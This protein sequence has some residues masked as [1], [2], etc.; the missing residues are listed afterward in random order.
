MRNLTKWQWHRVL[1]ALWCV[2]LVG[3]AALAAGADDVQKCIQIAEKYI[4]SLQ[5]GVADVLVEDYSP[6][7][8]MNPSRE[9]LY[10]KATFR[11]GYAFDAKTGAVRMDSEG[12]AN[13]FVK[14]TLLEPTDELTGEHPD[15]FLGFRH[16]QFY[17]GGCLASLL[18]QD[19]RTISVDQ[20]YHAPLHEEPLADPVWL[21]R[22]FLTAAKR[23][24]SPAWGT[25]FS[26]DLGIAG[27][28]NLHGTTQTVVKKELLVRLDLSKVNILH[29]SGGP[30]FSHQVSKFWI[31][32]EH[33][34][35]ERIVHLSHFLKESDVEFSGDS[36]RVSKSAPELFLGADI[37][38]RYSDNLTPPFPKEIMV[39]Y[40]IP[41]V[42]DGK[43]RR[44]ASV[45]LK[46]TFDKI[47]VNIPGL[48]AKD[49]FIY[50]EEGTRIF[51]YEPHVELTP[52]EYFQAFSDLDLDRTKIVKQ[53][54][55]F[56]PDAI[57]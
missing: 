57:K 47:R 27:T 56:S 40:Y 18:C 28:D 43:V 32:N 29:Y 35:V 8:Q 24:A 53:N 33:G 51:L 6:E 5:N 19:S 46:F 20:R 15:D 54:S 26:L 23:T 42:A 49:F 31:N 25:Q 38:A 10:R 17:Y 22:E 41:T 11:F 4:N 2:C 36:Y 12:V 1:R 37:E 9:G 21:T 16:L 30:L 34:Y 52:D 44:E 14:G 48:S 50:P 45:I 39:R 55:F 7:W 3:C 13:V